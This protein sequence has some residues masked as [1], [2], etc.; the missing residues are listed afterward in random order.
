MTDRRELTLLAERM[1]QHGANV[2][3]GYIDGRMVNVRITGAAG[4]GTH[5]MPLLSAAERMREWLHEHAA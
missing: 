4:V 1:Q 2:V 3:F 5:V